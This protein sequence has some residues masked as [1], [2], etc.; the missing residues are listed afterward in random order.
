MEQA[1]P[2]SH[3]RAAP[4]WNRIH[5]LTSTLEMSLNEC[6]SAGTFPSGLPTRISSPRHVYNLLV[7]QGSPRR[8][9]KTS[10]PFTSNALLWGVLGLETFTAAAWP[11]RTCVADTG[12]W[13][14]RCAPWPC[15]GGVAHCHVPSLRPRDAGINCTSSRC[16]RTRRW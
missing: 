6:R 7:F 9:K 16:H 4:A 1:F 8:E 10:I 3:Q 15:A 13:D 2:C 14:R 11:R 5:Y 12:V